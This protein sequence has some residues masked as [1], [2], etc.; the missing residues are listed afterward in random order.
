MKILIVDDTLGWVKFHK[1]ALNSILKGENTI[2]TAC[3][4]REGYDKIMQSQKTPYELIITD[5]QMENDFAPLTAGQWLVQQVFT[6]PN[7]NTKILIVSAMYNIEYIA[8]G[9]SVEYL[10]KRLLVSGGELPLK[11]KLQEMDL[12]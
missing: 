5:L 2:D 3:C 9:L 12:I 11:L 1:N 8:D 10:S 7:Y 4:A 6:Y